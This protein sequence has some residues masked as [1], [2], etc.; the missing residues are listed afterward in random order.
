MDYVDD[1]LLPGEE[2][3]MRVDNDFVY[4]P[5][6]CVVETINL[7]NIKYVLSCIGFKGIRNY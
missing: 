3:G 1:I 2:V 4:S 7:K 5:T 6:I